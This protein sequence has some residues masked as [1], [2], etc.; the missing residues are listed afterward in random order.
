MR[1]TRTFALRVAPKNLRWEVSCN[2]VTRRMIDWLFSKERA[3]THAFERGEEL[4]ALDDDA[5]V[6]ITVMRPDGSVEERHT[7]AAANARYLR[8]G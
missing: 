4:V 5:E 8:A 7:I 2:G 3:V 1:P 6:V